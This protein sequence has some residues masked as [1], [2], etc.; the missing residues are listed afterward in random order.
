MEVDCVG[1]GEI[2]NGRSSRT[3]DGVGE[4]DCVGSG[5]TVNGGND[6]IGGGD[7]GMTD[8]GGGRVNGGKNGAAGSDGRGD[9]V[10]GTMEGSGRSGC[11]GNAKF[12]HCPAPSSLRQSLNTLRRYLR[13]GLLRRD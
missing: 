8:G 6:A 11:L 9:V 13:L 12:W 2:V 4:V 10:C 3:E 7:I 1:S 5:D